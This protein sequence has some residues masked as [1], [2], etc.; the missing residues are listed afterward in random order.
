MANISMKEAAYAYA[1]K[2]GKPV[3]IIHGATCGPRKEDR[4]CDECMRLVDEFWKAYGKDE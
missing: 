1:D 3:E 2:T 4:V